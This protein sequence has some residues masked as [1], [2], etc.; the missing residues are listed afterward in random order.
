M[1]ST[2]SFVRGG[3]EERERDEDKKSFNARY[4]NMDRKHD[5]RECVCI[6]HKP[7]SA[8][9]MILNHKRNTHT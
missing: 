5:G 1:G 9:C 3:E 7:Q 4:V 2:T 6:F 8:M